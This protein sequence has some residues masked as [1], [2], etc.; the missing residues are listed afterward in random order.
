MI[1]KIT[2]SEQ[3]GQSS[4]LKSNII[5]L[6]SI[7]SKEEMKEFEKF[8]KSPFHNN[9]AEVTRFFDSIKKFY[10]G[11]NQK[12]FTK[13]KI[14]YGLYSGDKYRDDVVRRLCSNLYNLGEEF[15]AY[16]NFRQD[17]FNSEKSILDFFL[18]RN[19][20]KFYL[21]QI[22]KIRKQL[23]DQVLRDPE[24]Y[25]KL[26]TIE[27]QYRVFMLKYDPN[28]K[29]VSFNTQIDLMWK[30][31]LS[32]MLR[33]Y[34]FAEYEKFF[35]NKDYELKYK[36]ELLKI[37]LESGFMNSKTVEIYYLLL[38]LYD[39]NN[40]EELFNRIKVLIDGISGSFSKSE[41]F[42]FYIHLFNYLNICK[43]NSDKDFSK[44][45]FE[46]SRKLV[47]N[48]LLVHNGTI[49]PGW[50]RGIFA[51][52][53]NA[54][55]IVFADK[56]IEKYKSMVS[57]EERESVVNHIY[58]SLEI[59]KK[60]YDTA[61]K[62]LEKAAYLHLNDKW[63]VKNMYLT[64]YYELNEYKLFFYTVD[65]IKHLISESGLWNDN[66]IIPIRNFLNISTKLFKKK[67]GEADISLEELKHQTLNTKV[68]A[69]KWLLDK[70]EELET[71]DRKSKN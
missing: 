50:F 23:E 71:P 13:E 2:E 11:F 54:G 34:G 65:S 31:L 43:M 61:L 52:A 69:R 28:Y 10:P 33:L 16:K 12:D 40:N 24:Y 39:G 42:H 29:K 63:S 59:Y 26:S 46:I 18:S 15:A 27:E 32:S 60:N 8:V 53:L 19:A 36:D 4:F 22:S 25:L 6:L 44:E 37:S 35:F 49:D 7:F 67:I 58:A 57:G 68:R 48:D 70:I 20:D 1:N 21:K 56:F 47:E 9:R 45:E 17:S 3:K 62:Y 41:C 55:E 14:F 64:V 30:F 38:K 5:Q 66:L 51:K